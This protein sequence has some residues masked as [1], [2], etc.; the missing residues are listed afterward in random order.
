MNYLFPSLF[1]AAPQ[2]R[3]LL[4][5]PLS[6]YC[7]LCDA[8]FNLQEGATALFMASQDGHV[9][10]VWRLVEAGASLDVQRKVSH[11]TLTIIIDGIL[12]VHEELV[13]SHPQLY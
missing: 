13:H 8:F 11:Y 3:P 12:Q 10:T 2:T 9:S 7:I 5:T 1:L 6:C 4:A